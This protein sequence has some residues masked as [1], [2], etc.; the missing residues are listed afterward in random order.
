MMKKNTTQYVLVT[1]ICKQTQIM[2]LRHEPLYK[3]LEVKTNWFTFWVPCWDVHYDIR[4]KT[5]TRR[6]YSETIK[7]QREK[8]YSDLW[9]V[10]SFLSGTPVSSTNKIDSQYIAEILLKV[11][12]NTITLTFIVIIIWCE[13]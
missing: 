12:L 1:T 10:S 3:Q 13:F 11:V 6:Y 9:Q 5:S 2:W 7:H 4:I 8:N